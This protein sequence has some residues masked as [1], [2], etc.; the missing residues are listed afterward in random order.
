MSKKAGPDGSRFASSVV[1]VMAAAV[2]VPMTV[3][4]A[5]IDAVFTDADRK[6]AAMLLM[7]MVMM[8]IAAPTVAVAVAG[9][10]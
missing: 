9:L 6:S 5:D 7:M 10:C 2:M 1:M 8:A 4:L 3:L